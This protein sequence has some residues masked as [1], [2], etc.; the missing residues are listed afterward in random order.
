MSD[1]GFGGKG[2]K[3]GKG[4]DFDREKFVATLKKVEKA[5]KEYLTKLDE[6]LDDTQKKAWKGLVGDAFD[7]T[8]LI[9]LPAAKKD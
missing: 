8:K 3:G 2:G 9:N 5:R 4:K 7:T 1:A 6:A